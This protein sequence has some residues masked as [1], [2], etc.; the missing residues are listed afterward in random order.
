MINRTLPEWMLQSSLD[1]DSLRTS[2]CT[3]Q[4]QQN[5]NL[6]D[7][8]RQETSSGVID[9]LVT[10]DDGR[11]CRREEC[12]GGGVDSAEDTVVEGLVGV[13][14]DEVGEVGVGGGRVDVGEE[15]GLGDTVRLVG[16]M[17]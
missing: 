10:R 5:L 2:R 9:S 17:R 11:V 6:A 4:R 16:R 8:L 1:S 14:A 13:G 7:L 12:A 15:L 3:R